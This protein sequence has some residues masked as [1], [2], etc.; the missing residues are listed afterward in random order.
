MGAI[1]G[2]R[3]VDLFAGSGAL[4]VEALSRGAASAVLVEPD[5]STRRLIG[6]NLAVLD[7]PVEARV[8][9]ATA[10]QHLAACPP[11]VYDLAFADPPYDFD[12]WAE[13]FGL[14]ATPLAPDG[15]VVA[16]S[17]RAIEPPPGWDVVRS[18]RYGSTVV[19]ITVR[20]A[21]APPPTGVQK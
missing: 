14:L 19:T 12:D 5:A 2:A 1:V 6:R 4:A 7:D 10:Q 21:S 20:G 11:A 18:R 8:V 16:E 13:L 15:V 3:V 17:D 9:A